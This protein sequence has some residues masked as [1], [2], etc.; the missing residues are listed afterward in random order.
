MTVQYVA[1]AMSCNGWPVN[2]PT[3]LSCHRGKGKTPNVCVGATPAGA[4]R[5]R[6]LL[7][8][9]QRRPGQ[10]PP[11]I[12]GSSSVRSCLC[13]ENGECWLPALPAAWLPEFHSTIKYADFLVTFYSTRKLSVRVCSHHRRQS[14]VSND[15]GHSPDRSRSGRVA[16][17]DHM[18]GS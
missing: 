14:L 3:Q 17:F 5:R 6:L 8:A 16:P 2:T 12:L 10:G 18:R 1:N 4:G 7:V 9:E 13:F 11:G 15:T